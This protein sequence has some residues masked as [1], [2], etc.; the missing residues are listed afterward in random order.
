MLAINFSSLQKKRILPR[1]QYLPF[2]VI[3]MFAHFVYISLTLEATPL[4]FST[5]YAPALDATIK[6]YKYA[7]VQMLMCDIPRAD[8]NDS[9]CDCHVIIISTRSIYCRITKLNY[10]KVKG[11][12]LLYFSEKVAFDV[13]WREW[14]N[15]VRSMSLHLYSTYINQFTLRMNF[16]LIRC[17]TSDFFVN[18]FSTSV[19]IK[20]W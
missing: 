5:V 2:G 19:W 8:K 11:C 20:D 6:K 9:D 14:N 17:R 12:V 4:T 7:H 10:V 18:S 1:L 13:I 16:A 15:P 3:K